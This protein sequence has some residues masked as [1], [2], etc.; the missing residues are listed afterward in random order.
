MLT[1]YEEKIDSLDENN[2]ISVRNLGKK[3]FIAGEKRQHDTLR[4]R[5]SYNVKNA[6]KVLK[7][8]KQSLIGREEFWA[9]KE[10]SFDIPRGEVVGIVGRNGAGKSTLLKILTRITTPTEGYARIAGR[11]GSLLEVGTG[12]HHELTGRENVFLSG[13]ILGMSKKEIAAKFNDIIEFSGISKFV[14]VPVKRYS[15]GMTVR[16]GFAVA[17]HLEPEILLIDEVLAVGDV[18]FQ[19]KCLG[20]MSDVANSGRTILFVSHNMGAIRKLCSKC[21]LLDKGKM[22]MYDDTDKIIAA[23]LDD[24]VQGVGYLDLAIKTDKTQFK[25]M[26]IHNDRNKCSSSFDVMQPV[27][28]LM[29]YV[30][31]EPIKGVVLSFNVF[32]KYGSKVFVSQNSKLVLNHNGEAKPGNYIATATIPAHFLAP[33]KFTISIGIHIPKV[34]VFDI[35]ENVIGF[36]IIESGSKEYFWAGVDIGTVLVDIPWDISDSKALM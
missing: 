16:L 29:E 32:D 34:Q 30:I 2:V 36:T 23:Y 19:K 4:D 18:A 24:S 5:V 15:S 22:I 9:L 3:Y 26:A 25:S 27:K 12:F 7:E 8:R 14:D 21:I 10:V 33:G 1:S 6:G 31:A 11:V 13:A 28:L 17:A 35:H 20:K